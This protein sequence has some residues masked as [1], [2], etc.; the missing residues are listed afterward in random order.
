MLVCFEVSF[1]PVDEESD[2]FFGGAEGKKI[3]SGD[4]ILCLVD[5]LFECC[6]EKALAIRPFWNG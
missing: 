2:A 5:G 1:E 6:I 3:G 4:A